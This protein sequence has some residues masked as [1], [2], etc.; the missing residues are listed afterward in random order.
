MRKFTLSLGT[1]LILSLVLTACG[2]AK[3]VEESSHMHPAATPKTGT[4]EA[5]PG[6]GTFAKR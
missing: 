1:V 5:A 2:S 6:G 3:V 4:G